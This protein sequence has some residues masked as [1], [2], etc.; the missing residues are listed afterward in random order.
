MSARKS[1][2]P[3]PRRIRAK[4]SFQALL[5]TDRA[6]C[7]HSNPPKEPF[8]EEGENAER[9]AERPMSNYRTASI[10]A[11]NS[12]LGVG[13]WAFGVFFLR[14]CSSCA[15]QPLALTLPNLMR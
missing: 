15:A 1:N 2:V 12:R 11:L 9:N 5:L 3:T 8:N 6:T 7:A 4:T 10:P 13:R 14:L